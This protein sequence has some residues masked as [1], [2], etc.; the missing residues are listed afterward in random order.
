MNEYTVT[1]SHLANKALELA[2]DLA[3]LEEQT[4]EIYKIGLFLLRRY[5][6]DL[7]KEF[8][9]SRFDLTDETRALAKL[10]KV[11]VDNEDTWNDII[12]FQIVNKIKMKM[13]E[14]MPDPWYCYG[15]GLKES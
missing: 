5:K 12:F 2:Q 3:R 13:K 10:M 1:K 11:D 9:I 6:D 4:D 7:M 14:E 8:S 15:F